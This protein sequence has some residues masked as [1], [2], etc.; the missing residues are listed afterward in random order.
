[1]LNEGLELVVVQAADTE[2]GMRVGI[3]RLK[4]RCVQIAGGQ[5]HRQQRNLAFVGLRNLTQTPQGRWGQVLCLI[6]QEHDTFTC[7]LSRAK[8]L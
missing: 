3:D 6:H 2:N 7:L 8:K 4:T 1:M 5:D